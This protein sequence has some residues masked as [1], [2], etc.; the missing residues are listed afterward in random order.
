MSRVAIVEKVPPYK[1]NGGAPQ[2]VPHKLLCL[3]V[4]I[5][6]HKTR[7]KLLK[8]ICKMLNRLPG[9]LIFSSQ[10]SIKWKPENIRRELD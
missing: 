2:L 4:Y 3:I 7:V 5:V 6:K 1:V 9:K 10:F 8:Q